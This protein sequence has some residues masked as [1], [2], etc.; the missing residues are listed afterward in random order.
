MVTITTEHFQAFPLLSL[1]FFHTE[2]RT[3]TSG[4]EI[5][6]ENLASDQIFISM[7]HQVTATSSEDNAI[8]SSLYVLNRLPLSSFFL[9]TLPLPADMKEINLKT[10][11]KEIGATI[12]SD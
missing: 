9:L 12:G 4:S 5:Y 2:P 10:N 7:H 8:Q 6:Q 3:G 1:P 11:I